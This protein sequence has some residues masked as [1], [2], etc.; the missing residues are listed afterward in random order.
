[1]TLAIKELLG[2][3]AIILTI[4][5][6]LPYIRSI[7]KGTTKPHVFSWV[8]W[9]TTTLIVFMAQ[10]S[11]NGGAG[12]WPLGVSGVIT[13]Y[14]AILAYRNKSDSTITKSDWIFFI[15][16]MTA[17]PFWYI[18]SN[19][20]YAVLLLTTIDMVG[21]LP[22]IRKAYVKPFEEQAL[23]YVLMMLQ[24]ILSIAALENYSLT[25]FLFPLATIIAN[26]TVAFA[27]ASGRRRIKNPA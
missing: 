7:I 27:L 22:T 20:L 3:T 13:F 9:G 6:F 16:A 2:I 19:P 17:I 8:I 26:L 25:T 10:L 1:M 18:T 15:M 23:L 21:Y 11:D 5:A 24:N 12:A 4:I 14:V